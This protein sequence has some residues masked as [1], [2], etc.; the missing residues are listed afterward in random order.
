MVRIYTNGKISTINRPVQK[1]VP[2]EVT[3]DESENAPDTI[4]ETVDDISDNVASNDISSENNV[5]SK[6][7]NDTVNP[8]ENVNLRPRRQAA[9]VGELKRRWYNHK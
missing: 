4:T 2:L 1:L 6:V 3:R 8:N 7:P 9:V 5:N